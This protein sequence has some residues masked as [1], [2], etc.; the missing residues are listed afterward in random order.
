LN[1][2]LSFNFRECGRQSL[3]LPHSSRGQ[4]FKTVMEYY[5]NA[6]FSVF[7]KALIDLI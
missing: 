6:H 7:F 2:Q 3:D 5:Y 4:I 1:I